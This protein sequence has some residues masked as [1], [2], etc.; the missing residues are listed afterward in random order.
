MSN[1]TKNCPN[2]GAPLSFISENHLYCEYCDWTTIPADSKLKYN[3]KFHKILATLDLSFC[4]LIV[5]AIIF[6]SELGFLGNIHATF[7][8][9]F[10][11]L[12]GVLELVYSQ[13][14]IKIYRGMHIFSMILTLAFLIIMG[15]DGL[16]LIICY[17][18]ACIFTSYYL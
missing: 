15:I 6:Y 9:I 12:L 10:G 8:G 2:C 11:F 3:S 7:M 4:F 5:T 1:T 17:N 13:K 18:I 14:I 16:V